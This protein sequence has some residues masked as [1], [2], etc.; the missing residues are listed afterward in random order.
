MA[1]TGYIDYGKTHSNVPASLRVHYNARNRT[2]TSVIIDI[3]VETHYT[4]SWS[5]NGC[6]VNVNS[7]QRRCNTNVT[8]GKYYWYTSTQGNSRGSSQYWK[9][10]TISG[11]S[12]SATTCTL[13]VGFS[14]QYG[15]AGAYLY[16]TF[17]FTIP[18]G[19]TPVTWS[20]PTCTVSPSGTIVENT[21]SLNVSW[22]GASDAQGD[23]IYYNTQFF[24]NGVLQSGYV[25]GTNTTNRYGSVN[26]ASD[27]AG[28]QYH[29]R[30]HARDTHTS[31]IG[32]FGR[33]S[34]TVTKNTMSAPTYFSIGS[35]TKWTPETESFLVER[36]NPSNTN[37]HI[38]FTYGLTAQ[39]VTLNNASYGLPVH[40]ETDAY[41]KYSS[42]IV[43]LWD[44]TGSTP[45]G[46]YILKSDILNR[47]RWYSGSTFQGYIRM[48][49]T[50]SNSYGS[51]KQVTAM[52][53][54]DW[55]VRPS[56][57]T[58]PVY[59][60]G[61]YYNLPNGHNEVFLINRRSISW[62]WG[63]SSDAY[64][65]AISYDV[66]EKIGFNS[67]SR[68]TT[69]ST[70]SWTRYTMN[71]S[72][73]TIYQ[74]KVIARTPY[75]TSSEEMVGPEITLHYYNPPTIKV[76]I[77]E[78]EQN[79]FTALIDVKANSSLP[80]MIGS[81]T[82]SFAGVGS[83]TANMT[84]LAPPY[85]SDAIA[86]QLF[87][88]NVNEQTTGKL[89][90]NHTDSIYSAIMTGTVEGSVQLLGWASL[91]SVRE[92]GVGI[93]ALAGDTANFVVNGPTTMYNTSDL[94]TNISSRGITEGDRINF[95]QGAYV[96]ANG[97][98]RVAYDLPGGSMNAVTQWQMYKH[99]N[100]IDDPCLRVRKG[101]VMAPTA[102]HAPISVEWSDWT[103]YWHKGEFS[104]RNLREV[105]GMG[106]S[107]PDWA[108]LNAYT[109]EGTYVCKSN[110]T[111]VTLSNR[112]SGMHEY[113]TMQVFPIDE[114]ES[115]YKMQILWMEGG[116][117]F[118][119]R[120]SNW[121]TG[122]IPTWTAWM[123]G[124]MGD[125]SWT[126]INLP[127]NGWQTYGNGYHS[128]AYRRAGGRVELRGMIHGGTVGAGCCRL[129]ADC[130]SPESVALA[131]ISN[132][133][134]GRID[135][136]TNGELRIAAPSNNSWV[137]LEG[138]SYSLDLKPPPAVPG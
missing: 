130:Y 37:G 38:T 89:V 17:T 105:K 54:V 95:Y 60:A 110:A 86:T 49:L 94:P 14:N 77:S 106:I 45:T 58:T 88:N 44:G 73:Q 21:K 35:A 50:V 24:K 53:S 36:N 23:P 66:Y 4:G 98:L 41:A 5:T 19:N 91:F 48:T 131:T 51:S 81:Q 52:K 93:N 76:S 138:L 113:F 43:T 111:A 121:G 64:S 72:S 27:P 31:G 97:V 71:I 104:D 28:T 70:T 2:A 124:Y 115:G 99:T 29:F 100:W 6:W 8:S 74:I 90:V 117:R 136:L 82:M 18:T 118:Y 129:P 114:Y 11:L 69:V 59:S 96:D 39:W 13:S 87:T 119:K 12:A 7:D 30:T 65:S 108:N 33:Q 127:Y 116:G 47:C 123:V 120:V 62:S 84:R 134:L 16:K 32:A 80:L 46:P 122:P 10:V 101:S 103:D 133:A 15:V 78:R 135:V 85:V 20:N 75:G 40:Q 102:A 61:S 125:V 132:N 63:A 9:S 92:K 79:S 67:W 83:G 128:P 109:T 55:S 22:S 42:F 34:S 57:P 56:N 68:V 1:V 107:I 26:I 126:K 3:D 112:P 137:S 25:G